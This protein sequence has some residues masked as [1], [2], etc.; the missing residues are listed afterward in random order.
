[1][2]ST[3]VAVP[4]LLRMQLSRTTILMTS[5]RL[6]LALTPAAQDHK[7]GEKNKYH[8]SSAPTKTRAVPSTLAL[9][10]ATYDL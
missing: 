7:R 2:A 4:L 6:A 10:H 9:S 3:A 1:M 5:L 8:R